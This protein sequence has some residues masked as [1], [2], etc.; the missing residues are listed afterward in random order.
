M[1]PFYCLRVTDKYG[2]GNGLEISYYT[3][4]PLTPR[5]GQLLIS[6]YNITPKSPIKVTRINEMIK[7]YKALDF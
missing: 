1:T 4:K 6:P 2:S 5:R 3:F 7:T